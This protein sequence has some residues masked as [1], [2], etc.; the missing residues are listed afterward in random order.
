MYI[1]VNFKWRVVN[2]FDKYELKLLKQYK[3]KRNCFLF[4]SV[5]KAVLASISCLR[6]TSNVPMTPKTYLIV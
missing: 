3:K 4:L 1:D 2:A 5:Q 6:I